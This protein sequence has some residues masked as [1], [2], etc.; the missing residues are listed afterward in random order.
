MIIQLSKNI[1]FIGVFVETE[2]E[3]DLRAD[4]PGGLADTLIFNSKGQ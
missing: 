1:R 3:N 2:S 4:G